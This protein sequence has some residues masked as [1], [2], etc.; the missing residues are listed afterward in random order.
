[1][2]GFS[3]T[4]PWTTEAE[5]WLSLKVIFAN[6]Q[7]SS[8]SW[9]ETHTEKQTLMINNFWWWLFSHCKLSW[10]LQ[11]SKL[12]FGFADS[13]SFSVTTTAFS[14]SADA[15]ERQTSPCLSFASQLQT[16][17]SWFLSLL[18]RREIFFKLIN[19]HWIQ[20]RR[21]ALQKSRCC[22]KCLCFMR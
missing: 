10:K 11:C 15:C 17:Q 3:S 5:E 8:C 7:E 22:H 1:M 19:F 12:T 13:A 21:S 4:A 14:W 20:W 6:S 18:I 16:S 2:T 9:V